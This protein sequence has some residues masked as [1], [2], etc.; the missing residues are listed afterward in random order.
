MQ[1][2]QQLR[3]VLHKLGRFSEAIDKYKQAI[4]LSQIM[5]KQE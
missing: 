3:C 2:I 1:S 5:L 4:K